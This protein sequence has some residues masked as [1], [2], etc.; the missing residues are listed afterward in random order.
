MT[1][2][3]LLLDLFLGICYIYLKMFLTDLK[4]SPLFW[5]LG[6]GHGGWA[7]AC[8]G[9]MWDLRIEPRLQLQKCQV[10][11]TRPPGK[12]QEY[13]ISLTILANKDFWS[14]TNGLVGKTYQE[15]YYNFLSQDIASSQTCLLGLLQ[16]NY[17][18]T[19]YNLA[20]V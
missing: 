15:N 1:L 9:L 20:F 19:S 16:C 6:G 12:S 13:H 7:I 2:S 10:L 14:G 11:T 18:M 17:Q 3:R 5:G 8:S 4:L